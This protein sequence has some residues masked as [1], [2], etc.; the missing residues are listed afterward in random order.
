MFRQDTTFVIGAGASCELGLPSGEQLKSDI[1]K[2][3]LSTDQNAY[4]LNSEAM[5]NAIKAYLQSF[6]EDYLFQGPRF[7]EERIA[8]KLAASRIF[9]GLPLALSIDNFLHTH[10]D[11]EKVVMLGKTAIA[12]TILE[13]ESQSAFFHKSSAIRLQ[14]AYSHARRTPPTPTIRNERITKSWYL[15]FSQLLM[16]GINKKNAADAFSNLRFIIF[17]YDR[18]FEQFLWSALQDYYDLSGDAAADILH[19]VSFI[20]PYGSLGPLPWQIDD[21]MKSVPLGGRDSIDYWRVGAGLRTFTES[22]TSDIEPAIKSA[23]QEASTIIFLGFGYLDQNVQLLKPY[24]NCRATKLITSAYGVPPPDQQII[25]HIMKSLSNELVSTCL[26]DTG[27]CSDVFSN[28]RL[29]LS[30]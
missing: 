6:T 28:F 22:V 8:I 17:N 30:N 20:H 27:T 19:T 15:P 16:S 18:C 1:I 9:R 25:T 24:Q 29:H 5:I 4:G 12:M 11:D 3:F 23:I 13:A 10:Q 26:I 2:L 14:D 7:Q 21:P